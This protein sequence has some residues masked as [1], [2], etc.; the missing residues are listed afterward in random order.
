MSFYGYSDALSQGTAFNARV[1]NYNDGVLL[2][3]QKAMDKYNQQVKDQKGKV[4]TD[5][6]KEKE[7]GAKY[8]FFD[9]AGVLSTGTG[10]GKTFNGVRE[11]GIAGFV[12]DETKGRVNTIQNTVKQAVAGKPPPPP[13]SMELGEINDDGTYGEA[14][15]QTTEAGENAA[16]A[17]AK[18]IESSGLATSLIKAGLKKASMGKIGE[19]GLSTLSE[20]GGKALGDFGGITD[21][22]KGFENLYNDKGFLAGETTADKFQEAGAALDLVGSVI[23]PLEVV[24]GI[25]SLIG[26][27]ME[28]WDDIKADI[29]KKGD[30][31]KKI[32]PPKQTAIKV[33][34]AFAQLGLVA[35]APISAKQS[36]TGS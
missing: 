30:D 3:N 27:A 7:D 1:K 10:I 35:S 9:T 29:E 16:A 8:G 5:A 33:S 2:A 23:P 26:G 20:V 13:A 36:I 4:A 21:M 12:T 25:T 32:P 34:P 6:L 18:E 15:V 17:G 19:A 28:T 24:G 22:A 14:L 11:K 31:A